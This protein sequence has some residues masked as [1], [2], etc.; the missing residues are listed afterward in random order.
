MHFVDAKSILSAKNG[1]NI[2]R[3]CTHGCIYCDSRSD[4][5]NMRHDFEDVEVKRNAPELLEKALASKRR[6]CMIGTGAMSDP[7]MH[8]EEKLRLTR[9]CLEVID[10]HGFGVTVLTKSDMILRDADLLCSINSKAKAVVQMTLTTYDEDLCRILEP[11]VCTTKRRHEV[12]EAMQKNGIPTVV[13]FTP[14][15]PFINDTEENLRGILS[16]C[17]DAGVKGIICM[18]IGTTLRDGDREY[19]YSALDRH[20]P[21]MKQRYI[22]QYGNEYICNSVNN[23]R[24]MSIFCNECEKHGVMYEPA[25]VFSYLYEFPEKNEQLSFFLM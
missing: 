11:N 3:G 9:R 19:F 15:L 22:S 21:G 18:G 6:L 1:M 25:K 5:Y 12:L 10:R 4:C 16:Y 14:V 2:Y 24:L 8:C 13:W 23:G 17:F 7:Y 20:F